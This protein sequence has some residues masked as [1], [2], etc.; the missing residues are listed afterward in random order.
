[1]KFSSF[2]GRTKEQD[3]LRQILLRD[4]PD[5]LVIQSIEGPGGIGKSTVFEKILDELNLHVLDFLTLRIDGNKWGNV[6]LDQLIGSF[7]DS[8]RSDKLLNKPRTLFSRTADA[9]SATERIRSESIE[10]LEKQ[11][12]GE[13]FVKVFNNAFD[14]M[15]SLGQAVNATAPATKGYLDAEALGKASPE[16]KEAIEKLGAFKTE[17]IPVWEKLGIGDSANLRNGLK[18]NAP[19]ILAQCLVDD[20]K[21]ILLGKDDSGNIKPG[22]GAIRGVRRLLLIVDDYESVQSVVAE[23][24]IS[25]FLMMVKNA[26]FAVSVI[27]LGRDRLSATHP[28]WD[29]H[30]SSVMANPLQ[31]RPLSREEMNELLERLDVHDPAEKERAWT[32]TR[33][34]PFHVTLWVEEWANGGRSALMLKQFHAR[35]TRWMTD[36][37][38]VWL[39]QLIH[40]RDINIAT[41]KSV[42]GIEEAEEVMTWFENEASVRDIHAKSFTVNEYVRSRLMEYLALRDPDGCEALAKKAA[43]AEG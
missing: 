1:M 28:S 14:A 17:S 41:L 13:D 18:K 12:G 33:G 5:G 9:I 27:I 21:G 31:I 29:Q 3:R 16:I 10:Q 35:I 40:M 32:D 23:F 4:D 25:N 43:F 24:L 37:Q 6:S 15:V 39:D 42:F 8:A 26:G 22:F 38:R 19:Q 20:L 36:R 11:K 7:V 34:Y 30:H 2:V